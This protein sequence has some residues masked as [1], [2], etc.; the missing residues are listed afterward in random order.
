M[1]R[2]SDYKAPG[3][4]LLEV[5]QLE[6]DLVSDPELTGRVIN[7]LSDLGTPQSPPGGVERCPWGQGCLGFTPGPVASAEEPQISCRK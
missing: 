6:T 2:P 3:R 1:V 7:I 5:F 4:L